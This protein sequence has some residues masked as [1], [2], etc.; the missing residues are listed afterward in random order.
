MRES[1]RL[2][3][4]IQLIE[5]EDST[6]WMGGFNRLPWTWFLLARIWFA[7]LTTDGTASGDHACTKSPE[8]RE[9]R[10]P[11][12]CT[13]GRVAFDVPAGAWCAVSQAGV[14]HRGPPWRI[15]MYGWK[16]MT[17]WQLG[18]AERVHK[19]LQK[20]TGTTMKSPFSRWGNRQKQTEKWQKSD[21]N[22][23]N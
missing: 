2:N 19:N 9:Q 3:E 4:R 7:W 17:K 1:N 12:A 10:E 14:P 6:A 23:Q 15:L 18:N 11:C 21:K 8:P 22:K 13:T 5:W 16:K 20:L